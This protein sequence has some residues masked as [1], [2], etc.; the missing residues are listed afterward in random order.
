MRMNT[1]IRNECSFYIDAAEAMSQDNDRI[2]HNSLLL[3]DDGV[4]PSIEGHAAIYL[5]IKQNTR[6]LWGD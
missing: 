5:Y 4:H 1:Y 3:L 6:Y 2:T